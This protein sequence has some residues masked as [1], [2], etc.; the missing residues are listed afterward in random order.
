VLK[1]RKLRHAG[2]GTGLASREI[3]QAPKTGCRVDSEDGRRIVA[4]HVRTATDRQAAHDMRHELSMLLTT[5]RIL[6]PYYCRLP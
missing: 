1:H 3:L 2:E 4:L 6:L 5:V